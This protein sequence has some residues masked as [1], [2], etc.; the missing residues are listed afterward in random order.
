MARPAGGGEDG[1]HRQQRE[2]GRFGNQGAGSKPEVFV[3]PG[4]SLSDH[5]PAWVGRRPGTT[6]GYKQISRWAQLLQLPYISQSGSERDAG[7]KQEPRQ[8][9]A[10]AIVRPAGDYRRETCRQQRAA[11]RVDPEVD[12]Q[13]AVGSLTRAKVEEIEINEADRGERWRKL[14]AKRK[15]GFRAGAIARCA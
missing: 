9:T 7:R 3:G 5:A 6:R 4:R 15:M 8:R 10:A 1:P 14:L 2:I 12:V 11:D 13:R